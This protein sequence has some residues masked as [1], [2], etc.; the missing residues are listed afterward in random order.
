MRLEQLTKRSTRMRGKPTNPNRTMMNAGNTDLQPPQA[1][2]FVIGD[3][4]NVNGADA[5]EVPEYVVTRTELREIARYWEDVFLSR[6]FFIFDTGQIGSTDLRIAPFAERRVNRIIGLLGQD[7]ID[8]VIEVRK[9][10]ARELGDDTW[11]RFCEYLGPEHVHSGRSNVD[12][13]LDG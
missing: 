4:N 12:K 13:R 5:F 6:A 2:G 3:V 8:A 10:F 7:A 11:K 1:G 9:Q